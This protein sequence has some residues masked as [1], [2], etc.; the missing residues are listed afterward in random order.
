MS[1]VSAL[2][3]IVINTR[4]RSFNL[5]LEHRDELYRY[6]TGIVNNYN[7]KMIR[8]NGTTNHIHMLVEL[9]QSMNLAD[10]MRN[11]KQSS[12][13]WMKNNPNFSKFNGWGREYFAFTCSWR[14]APAVKNYIDSQLEHHGFVAFEDEIER[15]TTRN[16]GQW[17]KEMLT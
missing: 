9:H 2:Y 1:F 14:E 4:N 7:C 6:I 16:G 15:I 12:S 3:H 5:Q 11:I 13:M 17:R 8:I 10:L